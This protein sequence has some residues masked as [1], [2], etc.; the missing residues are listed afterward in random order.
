MSIFYKFLVC[1]AVALPV[2]G[3]YKGYVGQQGVFVF[4]VV[5]ALAFLVVALLSVA[6]AGLGG[7]AAAAPARQGGAAAG[8]PK[9]ARGGKRQQGEVKWFNGGKG[10]GFISA[11]SGQEYFVH[12]R[13]V[14]KDS[15]RLHPGNRV[16]FS[17]VKG[18]KGDEADDVLVI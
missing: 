10:F 17:L 16:E 12:F 7:G 15:A 9:P 14:R 8:K 18:K 13:S 4:D 2:S 11:D 5:T 6:L 3:F 1:C